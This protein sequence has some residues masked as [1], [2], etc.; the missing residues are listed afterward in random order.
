MLLRNDAMQ[1]E[2]N[3][4]SWLF[5]FHIPQTIH[6]HWFISYR[7]KKFLRHSY[8]SQQVVFISPEF[9]SSKNIPKF[10]MVAMSSH[11]AHK[12][13][14]LS[15]NLGALGTHKPRSLIVICLMMCTQC[16]HTWQFL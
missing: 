14:V 6:E 15:V 11:V 1:E 5:E 16:L 12:T 9:M 10:H 13:I 8:T 4:F 2:R 7:L 3:W